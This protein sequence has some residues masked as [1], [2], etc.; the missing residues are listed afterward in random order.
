[1]TIDERI[2]VGTFKTGVITIRSLPASSAKG[3]SIIGNAG[4]IEATVKTPAVDRRTGL[5]IDLAGILP[6]LSFIAYVVDGEILEAG[7]V[8]AIDDDSDNHQIVLK[9]AGVRT[10]YEGR[11]VMAEPGVG[12]TAADV[13]ASWTGLSLR[14]LAKRA[15]ALANSWA[16]GSPPMTYEADVAGTHERNVAGVDFVTVDDFLD[17]I[18]SADGGPDVRFRPYFVNDSTIAWEVQT[19]N[20]EIGSGSTH[21]F[22]ETAKRPNVRGLKA[23]LNGKTLF[24][25]AHVTS[26]ELQARA[27]SSVLP[28]A[29]YLRHETHESR[30]KISLL[31]TLQGYADA[32]VDVGA[33]LET[34]WSF[35]A[36]KDLSPRLSSVKAGDMAR[37]NA[38]GSVYIAP[39][40]HTVRILSID[41]QLGS[42]YYSVK[43]AP[44]RT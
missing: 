13:S 19:G 23:S 27:A 6:L 29:G 4:S 10:Y 39:G 42:A 3:S 34:V 16:N 25:D 26:E 40:F 20:P 15:V 41:A 44:E 28:S 5:A 31:P 1:M 37:I 9:G 22:D 21:V 18:S 35:E 7:P 43:C 14:T 32:A 38:R 30:S 2:L 12:Q 17:S 11:H 24:S 8:W 33:N 36:R